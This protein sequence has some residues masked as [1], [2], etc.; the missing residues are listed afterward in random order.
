MA[1]RA[2]FVQL[3]PATRAAKGGR[4]VGNQAREAGTGYYQKH[5]RKSAAAKLGN[6]ILR[7]LWPTEY[8]PAHVPPQEIHLSSRVSRIGSGATG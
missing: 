1:V 4:E 3:A 7:T 5:G 8:N 2:G 6:P